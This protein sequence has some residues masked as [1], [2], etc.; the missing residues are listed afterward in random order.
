MSESLVQLWMANVGRAPSAVAVT[1]REARRDWTRSRLAGAAL[2]LADA[3]PRRRGRPCLAGRRVAVSVPNGAEWFKAFLAL[4]GAGASVVPIDPSEPE[5]GQLRAAACAGASHLWRDGA[6]RALGT[7]PAATVRDECVAKLTS[8]SSGAPKVIA[9]T[10]RQLA[11]DGRQIC[12]SM[13]IAPGD[14]NLAAIPLG[15]SY[16]LGSVV[17]PLLLQGSRAVCLA[18][19]LPHAIIAAVAEAG[20]TVFP[21]VPPMLGA[22]VASAVPAGSLAGLRLVISAGSPLPPGIARA[23]LEKFGLRVHGFYGTSETGGISYDRSGEATLEG[24]GVGTALAGVTVA[25]LPNGRI[26]V[27][28]AAV[29][30][31]G[32]FSPA[33]RASMSATGELSLLGRTD[34]VVKVAGRRVDLSEIEAALR[35]VPGVRDAFAHFEPGPGAALEAAVATALT[36]GDVRRILRERLAP[37]KI[38]DRI[39]V[40][41]EFPRTARGKTDTGLLCQALAAPRSA[42]SI[43]T[44]RVLRHTSARR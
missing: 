16:G 10:H 30:G 38:P 7:R 39:A 3:F 2:E 23:F 34:R 15:Y 27:A 5:E 29:A 1:D 14:S 9:V 26:R 31:K 44:L 18:G 41:A 24:R 11:A 8:G 21:A 22:L 37:W 43:S 33:D 20:A 35:S 42:T 12:E 36:A 17:A 19:A 40:L 32:A 28:S 6:L 13:G 4:L 25:A